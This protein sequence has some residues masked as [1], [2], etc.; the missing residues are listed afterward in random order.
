LKKFVQQQ[1]FR[2]EDPIKL[3]EGLL[4]NGW[5][6]AHVERAI[7]EVYGFKRKVMKISLFVIVSLIV[8]LSVSLLFI[9]GDLYDVSEPNVPSLP[10][11]SLSEDFSNKP[12]SS[13]DD[14]SLKDECY[15]EK[16]RDGF[17]CDGLSG[18]ELFFCIRVLEFSILMD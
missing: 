17:E 18:E 7:S 5:D 9:F 13:F 10:D 15:F 4:L 1:A 11:Q 12:C 2:G 8:V 14:A 3:K 6:H 16:V